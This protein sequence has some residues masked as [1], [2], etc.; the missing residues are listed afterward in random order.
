MLI[1]AGSGGGSGL[2]R[3]ASSHLTIGVIFRYH[4]TR[5]TFRFWPHPRQIKDSLEGDFASDKVAFIILLLV[6]RQ[7]EGIGQ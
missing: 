2:R 7:F 5:I 4:S 6:T 1:E 3:D